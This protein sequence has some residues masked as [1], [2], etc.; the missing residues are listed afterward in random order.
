[1][2]EELLI[3]LLIPIYIA[4]IGFYI[5]ASWKIYEKAG[6]PGWNCIV[7]IYN[8]YVLLEIVGRPPLWVILLFIPIVNIVIYII[9]TIDLAKVF[10][11][12]GG[13]AAGLIFLPMIFYPILGFGDAEYANSNSVIF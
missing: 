10:G 13:F 3:F 6:R 11:K 2:S 4:V 12:G 1:M 5:M 8:Y 9:V 7:P